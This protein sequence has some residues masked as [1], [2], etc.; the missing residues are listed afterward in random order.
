MT[1]LHL[2]YFCAAARHENLTRAAQE[3]RVSQPALSKMIRTLEDELGVQLFARN[4][5]QLT[6]SDDGRFFYAHVQRSLETLDNA[7]GAL[8]HRHEGKQ[9]RLYI[10]SADL[11]VEQLIVDYR[12]EHGDISFVLSSDEH[13]GARASIQSYDLV[14]HTAGDNTPSAGRQYAL[15]TERF[16]L[17]LSRTDPLCQRETLTLQDVRDRDFLATDTYG[18]N[19]Q[20][21]TEAG[22]TPHLVIMGQHL[23]TYMKMLEYEAGVSIVP[24][25]TIG[26]YLP[27]NRCFKPL[28][29]V[30][31]TR[32][33][34]ME[35]PA[36]RRA[37]H[38]EDFAHFCLARGQELMQRGL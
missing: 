37:A 34:V 28:A 17:C 18:L 31:R 9:I 1:L 27:E 33:I 16:G 4:G 21:C 19:F 6:L 8:A 38:V 30:Q 22:F 25:L 29:D 2:R 11:F 36:Q 12:R 24:E 10:R 7:V 14:V 3:L 35:M 26:P 13:G 15:L 20:L 32:T 23:N 5:H